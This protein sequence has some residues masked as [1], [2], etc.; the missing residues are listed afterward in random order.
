MNKEGQDQSAGDELKELALPTVCSSISYS[1]LNGRWCN[2]SHKQQ[3]RKAK[4]D[5]MGDMRYSHAHS[6]CVLFCTW[7]ANLLSNALDD[8]L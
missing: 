7:I 5:H 4:S 1:S 2:L 8:A 3:Q 6:S